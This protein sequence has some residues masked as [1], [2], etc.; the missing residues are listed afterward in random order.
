VR[1]RATSLGTSLLVLPIQ[2]SNS[3]RVVAAESG[4][5]APIRLIRV[6]LLET[7][8]LFTGTINVKIAHVFGM[9]RDVKGRLRD[10]EDY[11]RLGIRETG[12]IPYPPGYQPLGGKWP[13][14]GGMFAKKER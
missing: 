10:I 6:N 2:F 8:V 4:A 9:F 5:G 13:L 7:G 14:F 3:L 11:K 12:V 1:V